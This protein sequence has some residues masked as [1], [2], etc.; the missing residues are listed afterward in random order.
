MNNFRH[1]TA[2]DMDTFI[3]IKEMYESE[4]WTERDVRYRSL[5]RPQWKTYK[6]RY[7]NIDKLKECRFIHRTTYQKFIYNVCACANKE[8]C[9]SHD[10]EI[11]FEEY[12]HIRLRIVKYYLTFI[13]GIF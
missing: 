13:L 11:S 4:I 7:S 8:S 3:T 12:L 10:M 1:T 9:Q 2:D 5:K 6:Q